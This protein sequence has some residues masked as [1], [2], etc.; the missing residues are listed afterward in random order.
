MSTLAPLLLGIDLGTSA[1]KAVLLNSDGVVAHGGLPYESLTPREGWVE[2]L[3]QTWLD[4]TLQVARQLLQQVPQSAKLIQAIGFSGQMHGAVVLDAA[5]HPLRPA[6]I[7]A[8]QRSQPQVA[9]IY[10]KWGQEEVVRLTGN[11]LFP[12]FM[13]PTLL[14]LRENEPALW[15]QTRFALLPKDYLRFCFT[16]HIDSEPSDASSTSLFDLQAFNWSIKVLDKVNLDRRIL[17][18]IRRSSDI[19]G[20]LRAEMAELLGLQAGIPVV[21]G[22]SD[23]AC[24]ALG[25]GVIAPGQLSSTI[26]TGGQLFAPV[27][28][29]VP[30]PQQRLHL[31]C[32][33]ME[34]AWHLEAATLAA[35]LSF[36][37]L[38]DI[39][40]NVSYQE[41]ADQAQSVEPGAEG[42]FFAP[43]LIGE[44]TP[45][46]D[47]ALRAG[48]TGLSIRHQ[49]RHLARAVME[50]V[51]FSLRTGL[52]LIREQGVHVD[53][54]VAAGGATK[55]PLWLQLQADIFN[56]PVVCS[57][58]SEPAAVG[59][60]ML[61]GVG[62]GIFQDMGSAVHS[63]VHY[64]NAILPRVSTIP[65]YNELYQKHLLLPE[66][67]KPF[68]RPA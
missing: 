1:V 24:Q 38:R 4:T 18:S 56:L 25:N 48:F 29:P 19:S 61:A 28:S 35:G 53:Q 8:D 27:S 57:V 37:W 20:L 5:H 46:M 55:H 22:G 45:Y 47:P 64:S 2:Q 63:L 58:H 15:S 26:G 52:D 13:L 6:I 11:P 42:L 39:L 50:G 16:G 7:W 3:P 9:E 62:A 68:S 66:V 44:R 14:W 41:L 21:C 34:N 36:R 12:G 33:I 31:F 54:I 10:E 40:G 49:R 51:V 43:Y 67:T 30:D 23:Q 17:P 32:H 59:A 60:A 65:V